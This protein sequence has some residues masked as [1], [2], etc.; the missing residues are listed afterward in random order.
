MPNGKIVFFGDSYVDNETHD[1]NAWTSILSM[2]LGYKTELQRNYGKAATSYYFSFSC[3]IKYLNSNQYCPDDILIFVITSHARLPLLHGTI[4]PQYA[5]HWRPF[6]DKT[7]SKM[8]KS[9]EFYNSDKEFYTKL[10]SLYDFNFADQFCIGI[11][12][13][14]KSL[15]NRTVAISAF[16]DADRSL[17]NKTII[18]SNDNF[19][20]INAGLGQISQDEIDRDILDKLLPVIGDP[21]VNH[22]CYTNHKVLADQILNCLKNQSGELFNSESFIKKIITK[23]SLGTEVLENEMPEKRLYLAK[24]H[25]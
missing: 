24:K 17:K 25:F 2:K 14:L 19:I 6:L 13:T 8:H 12:L 5:A 21:R 10:F 23:E 22:L 3:L 9:F 18:R 11:L 16:H 1:K 7:L 20:L 4:N 15:P